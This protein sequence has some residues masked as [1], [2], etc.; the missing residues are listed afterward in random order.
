MSTR[1]TTLHFAA[2]RVEQRQD[3][4]LYIFGVDGRSIHQIATV[5]FAERSA[6]GVL[7]GYQRRRV[8]THIAQIRA[9]LGHEDALMPNAIVVAFNGGVTFVPSDGAIRSRW[10]TPGR[11]SISLPG[12]REPKPGL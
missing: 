9:Y 4:P 5:N 3:V 10:G 2:L 7:T 12:P 8:E 11:L 6:D 1:K